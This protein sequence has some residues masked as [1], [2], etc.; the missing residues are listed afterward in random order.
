[1][2]I[3][4]KGAKQN[5]K[6]NGSKINYNN[7]HNNKL[8]NID[9]ID[10]KIIELLIANH[11]NSSI[12]Q[13]LDIPFSTIGRRTRRILQSGIITQ[14]Y[15]LNFNLLG[16]RKGL[17]H[18]YLRDGQI[19][20][21]AEMISEME[22]ILSVTIH[23]GNSDIVSEIVYYNSKESVKI[24]A[25]IKQ[26]EGVEKVIWSEEVSD[27]DIHKEKVLKSFQKYWKEEINYENSDKRNFVLL[28]D[29]NST[30]KM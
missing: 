29:D 5:K 4:V 8:V 11:D 13:K 18:I 26:I 3:R 20:K 30:K 15:Q 27:F 2:N 21:T 1:L 7:N 9:V 10:K 17:L 6:N 28:K 23:A 16:M 25:A 24:I 14:E 22:G 19:Q 12:S